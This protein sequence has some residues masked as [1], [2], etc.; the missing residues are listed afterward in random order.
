[1]VTFLHKLH[2]PFDAL[3]MAMRTFP[4]SLLFVA[5]AFLNQLSKAIPLKPCGLAFYDPANY[6]CYGTFLCPILDGEPTLKCGQDCYLPEQYSCVTR[7][8]NVE[9][10]I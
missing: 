10:P 6:T 2:I 9:L 8:A 4:A 1:M 5:I 3:K 7:D